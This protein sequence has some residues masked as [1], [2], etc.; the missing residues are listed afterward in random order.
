MTSPKVIKATA[1]IEWD[2]G[3]RYDLDFAPDGL[4]VAFAIRAPETADSF[5]DFTVLRPARGELQI[6]GALTNQAARTPAPLVAPKAWQHN[7][8]R[9]A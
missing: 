2:N 8:Y 9:V 4:E 1:C 3:L 7:K 5:S 6:K